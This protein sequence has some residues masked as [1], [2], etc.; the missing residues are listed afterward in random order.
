MLENIINIVGA[1][2]TIIALVAL[3]YQISKD[4]TYEIEKQ[5][6]SVASWVD[7]H[8][9]EKG[10]AIIFIS[11][12]SELPIY[13]VIVSRDMVYEGK[14]YEEIKC[15]NYAFIQSVPPGLYKVEIKSDGGCMNKRFDASITF[16]DAGG[17]Y[18]DRTAGGYLHPINM[19][20]IDY[21]KLDRPVSQSCIEKIKG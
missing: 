21:R 15:E 4:H 18:W 17:K 13:E 5:G 10:T 9:T 3:I 16:R 12:M 14:K 8:M 2:G 20:S 1:T 19:N 11:N 6:R 7:S